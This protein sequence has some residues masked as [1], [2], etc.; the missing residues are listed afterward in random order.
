MKAKLILRVFGVLS[1]LSVVGISFL[2]VTAGSGRAL[3]FGDNESAEEQDAVDNDWFML[4]RVYP[5]DDVDPILYENARAEIRQRALM[6]PATL[7]GQWKSIGPS[8]IGG[9]ITSIALHPTNANIIYAGAAGGGVWKSLD[10]GVNWTNVFNGSASIGSLI[11]SPANPQ[12]VYVGTGEGNP[13]GVAIYPGNGIWRST[14]GG[15]T[16]TNIGLTNTG[17]I[18]KLAIHPSS[19]NRIFAAALGRYRSRTQERGI[20][21]SLDSGATWQRVLFLNDTTGAC[22]VV[23]D[24][25]NQ[26]RI[27][28]AMWDR[29]R[30]LTYS[31]INGTNTG[32]WL[33]TDGGDNWTQCKNGFPFNDATSLGRISLAIAPSLNSTVYALASSGTGVKG[34]YRS[35]DSGNSWAQVLTGSPFS[36]ESQVW[37]NNFIAVHP[38]DPNFVL[39]GMTSLYK[40]TDGGATWTNAN[41]SMHVDHHAI[42]F[43]AGTPGRIVV[44]N[45]GGVFVSTN[46]GSTWSKSYHLP[47]SQ[48]Y[49]G[50]IDYSNPQR[51]LGGLQDN[52]TP[53]TMTGSD[54]DWSSIYGGDGFYALIDPT[55]PN[56]VYAESQNGGLGY[57]TNGGSSFFSGTS[58]IGS[59]DRKNWCTPIAMDLNNTLTLYT[60]THLLYKT[61]TG[62]QSWSAISGDLTR[63]ANGRIGTI[64]TIDVSQ[65]N[66]SVIYVG[67]DDGKVS[68]T[69]NG[70]SSWTNI[71][72]T[73]P[74][75]WVS[76]VTI[77]PDSANIAYVTQSGYLEDVFTSHLHKTR[78]FGQTWT[79]FGGD[80]P[81]VPLNDI[82]VDPVYK[83]YFYVATDLGVMVSSNGGKNWNVLGTGFPEVPVHDLVLHSP[84]RTLTAFT[85]GRSA[86]SFD[87]TTLTSV[88]NSLNGS[89]K[90]FRLEQNY[91]NPF[92]P[93]TNLRFTI[94]KLQF[95]EL[96]IVDALGREVAVLVNEEK[97]PGSYTVEW[98][99]TSCASGVYFYTL[100]AGAF[101]ET[102]KMLLVK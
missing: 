78:D 82:I 88:A 51:A 58:G 42:V 36:G 16:W 21:R 14:N 43:D 11:L 5:H 28:A 64:T 97:S 44:G 84:T 66:S 4:Q 79:D 73:L 100:K 77:D 60:G 39:A 89:P 32:L 87:L 18:G 17:Q 15:S 57:S 67:T 8:N 102:K 61:T 74:V 75:R 81:N 45:D 91:P 101:I 2:F 95:V 34:I 26:N 94:S 96:K 86:Y 48:F 37:Y 93:T 6:K 30:P 20:Y 55:N 31:V 1:L 53:R 71:T 7:A 35:T 29:Y 76:R 3:R 10:G 69:T 70:G 56:R 50:T 85:H 80:L 54:S 41:S 9:R 68:V 24:P 90:G 23:I 98:N 13:G 47:I 33:S 19:P 52:G 62:M 22:E 65:T 72:G 46:T 83:G 25:S 38:T 99:A 92:N 12:V 63:G 27:Y 40:S 49:A 59:S